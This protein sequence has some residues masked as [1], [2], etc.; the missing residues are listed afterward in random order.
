MRSS[1]LDKGLRTGVIFGIVIVTMFLIGFTVTGAGLVGKIFGVSSSYST[2]SLVYFSLFMILIGVWA[3]ASA[4]SRPLVEA[5]T[6]KRALTAGTSAGAVSGLF[7]AVI[8]FI[9][10]ELIANKIDPRTYLPSVSPE[11]IQ[12]FLFNQS[13]LTGSLMLYAV[14]KASGLAAAAMFFYCETKTR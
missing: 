13:P 14:L 3:G 5:D 9:F 10:G 11:S 7:S 4:S 8:G 2:P 12:L 1:A 6:W